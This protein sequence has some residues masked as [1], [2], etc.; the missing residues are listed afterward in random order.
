MA[1]KPQL[2]C[3]AGSLAALKA[4]VD[5]GADDV[6]LGFRNDTNARN[7]AG[8]NFDEKGLAEGIRYA[9]QRGRKVLAAINTYAQAGRFADWTASVDKAA[10]LGID[11]VIIADPAVLDYA[12][13]THPQMR[14]HLSVQ[15]SATSYEAINFCREKFGIQ[16]AVLP[17]LN[18][19]LIDR[20]GDDEPPATR[21]CA[22]AASRSRAKPTTPSKSRPASTCWKSCPRSSPA[23]RRSRSKDASAAR[24]TSR[25]SPAPARRARRT[26]QPTTAAFHVKPAWQAE[27]AKV[28]EGSQVTLGAYNRPWR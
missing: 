3:P 18:G 26:G 25:R 16:R 6:Y 9:H 4:A 14:R 24:P 19:I 10:T 1:A 2:V 28:A 21:P 13:Q 23:S 7:F 8:L 22:R 20:F 5:N 27:L 12:A 17:R 15:A 11:A